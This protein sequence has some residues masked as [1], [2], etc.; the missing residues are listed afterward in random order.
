MT[1]RHTYKKISFM[2]LDI[3]KLS[4][5]AI[6]PVSDVKRYLADIK[7]VQLSAVCQS[8]ICSST[9][10]PLS[11]QYEQWSLMD[12]PFPP[13]TGMFEASIRYV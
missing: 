12:V 1:R 2:A 13:S 8:V 5:S 10:A 11:G 7:I 9:I 3:F 4:G 6:R